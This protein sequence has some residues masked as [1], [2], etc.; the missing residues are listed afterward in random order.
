MKRS[1]GVKELQTM[2]LRE[3]ELKAKSTLLCDLPNFHA[4]K[5]T[6]DAGTIHVPSTIS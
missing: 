6:V 3:A 4:K 5:E 1:N 2:G